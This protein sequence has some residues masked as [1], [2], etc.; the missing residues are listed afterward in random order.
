MKNISDYDYKRLSSFLDGELSRPEVVILLEEMEDRAELKDLYFQ[1]VEISHASSELKSLSYK[2]KLKNLS[3]QNLLAIF[4]QKLVLPLTIFTV[5]AIM[6]YSVLV[7]AFNEDADLSPGNLL[8]EQ[9]I[10]S[11]EAKQV[12]ENIE[13]AEILQF[14]SRHYSHSD[15][16]ALIPVAYSPKWV[17][18]GFNIVPGVAN[19]FINKNNKKQFSVFISNPNTLNLP[20]GTYAKENFILIKKTHYL[21]EKPYT[22]AIFGDIDVESGRTILNSIEVTN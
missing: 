19:R 14:A 12:L 10:A 8:L 22:I 1:M 15:N 5:G 17:P 18:A 3:L 11:V 16:N 21:E 9:S 13:N 2:N 4:T 6:S 20:D 7:T